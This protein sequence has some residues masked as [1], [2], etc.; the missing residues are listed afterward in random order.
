MK[1]GEM[2]CQKF[3]NSGQRQ[4]QAIEDFDVLGSENFFFF[5]TLLRVLRQGVSSSICL[6]LTIINLEVVTREFLGQAD[7]S[8]AQTLYVYELAEVVVVRKHK[9]FMLRA[10]R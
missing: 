7:L 1:K 3:R 10:L 2:T 5:Y 9:N 8:R 4:L 6:T